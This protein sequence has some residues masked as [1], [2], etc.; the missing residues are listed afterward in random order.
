MSLGR[1]AS[2]QIRTAIQNFL[3][4]AALLEKV[5]E[6]VLIDVSNVI[7]HIPIKIGDY[8]DFYASKEHGKT[9]VGN[10]LTFI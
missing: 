5:K 8:T 9:S 4:N 3:C 6:T 7:N 1:P 10:G 2:K